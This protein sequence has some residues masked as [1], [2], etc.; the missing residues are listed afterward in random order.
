MRECDRL[1]V[2]EGVGVG[3]EVTSR[4]YCRLV[5]KGAKLNELSVG[6][7]DS[8]VYMRSGGKKPKPLRRL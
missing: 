7:V 5:I 3:C 4:M 8:P 6:E 2:K 1:G